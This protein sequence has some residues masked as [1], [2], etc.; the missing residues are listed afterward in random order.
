MLK[1]TG[2]VI[3]LLLLIKL[4]VYLSIDILRELNSFSSHLVYIN[5]IEI[6]LNI[7]VILSV[8]EL[9]PWCAKIRLR[10][11]TVASVGFEE[12]GELL[13]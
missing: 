2:I 13:A 7:I 4:F 6:I 11:L 12:E 10:T 3:I 5:I 9:V 8:L 1:E